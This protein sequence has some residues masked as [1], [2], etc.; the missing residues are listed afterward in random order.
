MLYAQEKTIIPKQKSELKLE[1]GAPNECSRNSINF[2][3][4]ECKS[5]QNGSESVYIKP[6]LIANHQGEVKRKNAAA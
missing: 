4:Q 6:S 5:Y 2:R 3:S 1:I